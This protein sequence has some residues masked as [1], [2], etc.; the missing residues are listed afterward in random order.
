MPGAPTATANCRT[1]VRPGTCRCRGDIDSALPSVG[2]RQTLVGIGALLVHQV[3]SASSPGGVDGRVVLDKIEIYF[4]SSG[5]PQE[6]G[7]LVGVEG[8]EVSDE[9]VAGLLNAGAQDL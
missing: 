1:P 6:A 5:G 9:H 7:E 2:L 8:A 4:R 3:A